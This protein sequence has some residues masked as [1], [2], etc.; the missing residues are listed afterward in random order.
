MGPRV[1]GLHSCYDED[2]DFTDYFLLCTVF[3]HSGISEHLLYS[4]LYLVTGDTEADWALSL[5]LTR[6]KEAHQLV[7]FVLDP[8]LDNPPPL[9]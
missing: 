8:P 9:T 2:A 3:T 6:T 4:K 7:N 5:I 1:H